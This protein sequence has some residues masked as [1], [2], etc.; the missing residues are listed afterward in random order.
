MRSYSIARAG[1]PARV[2]CL[3]VKLKQGDWFEA[4]GSKLGAVLSRSNDD[5]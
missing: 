5:R 2:R 4:H 3:R 1:G